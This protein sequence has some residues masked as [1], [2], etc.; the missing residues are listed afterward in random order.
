MNGPAP[1]LVDLAEFFTALV[2]HAD[3]ALF[4]NAAPTRL[5]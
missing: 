1:V 2:A 3:W 5:A 4:A